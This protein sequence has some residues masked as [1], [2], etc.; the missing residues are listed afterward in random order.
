MV[1]AIPAEVSDIFFE[2]S[3]QGSRNVYYADEVQL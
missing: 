2:S 3:T 1:F